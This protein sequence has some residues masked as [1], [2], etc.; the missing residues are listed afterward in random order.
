[1]AQLAGGN[2]ESACIS[3]SDSDENGCEWC[4]LSNGVNICLNSELAQIAEMIGSTCEGSNSPDAKADASN[5]SIS[6]GA[7]EAYLNTDPEA[8]VEDP[9]ETA[10]LMAQITGGQNEATC[11]S[12]YDQNGD[13]CEWCAI[14]DGL[15]FC[16]NPE[17]AQIAA[18]VGGTCDH[19]GDMKKDN[20]QNPLD[21]ACLM[22]S[23]MGND[24]G[25]ACL[26]YQDSDGNSCE[27]CTFGGSLQLCLTPE[28]AQ[29]AAVAGGT[30]DSGVS[31]ITTDTA[32][33]I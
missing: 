16:L 27:F 12:T 26:T 13:A 5:A 28:Q 30:C 15:N 14:S 25:K 21:T 6:A 33:K 8:N 29:I 17:Q 10:F 32:I 7:S 11:I 18:L 1:M 9:L 3:A 22:A 4:S 19:S 2:D 23:I 24:D 20:V 31:T